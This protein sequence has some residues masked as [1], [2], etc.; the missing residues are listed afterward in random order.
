M[1]VAGNIGTAREEAVAV[2]VAALEEIAA[3][4]EVAAVEEEAAL[5]AVRQALTRGLARVWWERP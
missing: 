1:E 4:G 2:V 3:S 5:T